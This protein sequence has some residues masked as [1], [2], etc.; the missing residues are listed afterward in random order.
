LLLH[1]VLERR[2]DS[3]SSI[4]THTTNTVD[5]ITARVTPNRTL[6]TSWFSAVYTTAAG[7]TTF[8]AYSTFSIQL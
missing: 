1:P 8:I 7:M 2:L 5:R 3:R 6:I 4:A